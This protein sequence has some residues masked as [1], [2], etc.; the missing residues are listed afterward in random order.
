MG[1]DYSGPRS[2]PE[3]SCTVRTAWISG[4]AGWE[5]AGQSPKDKGTLHQLPVSV[6]E[7]NPQRSCTDHWPRGTQGQSAFSI[8]APRAGSAMPCLRGAVRTASSSEPPRRGRG[9][10]SSARDGYPASYRGKPMSGA[11]GLAFSRI[12]APAPPALWA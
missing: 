9:H 12:R 1:P 8:C 4:P 6:N 5:R 2:R 3:A 10:I 7:V 11:S